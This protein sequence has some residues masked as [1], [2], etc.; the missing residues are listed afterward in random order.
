ME[1]EPQRRLE[2]LDPVDDRLARGGRRGLGEVSRARRHLG[3][4]EGLSEQL[5]NQE[6]APRQRKALEE[7]V[8]SE[9]ERP[10]KF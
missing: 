6:T 1:R 9:W 10:L 3:D 7:I 2:R 5:R 8:F 4:P